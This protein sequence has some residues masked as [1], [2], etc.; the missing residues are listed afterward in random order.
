M[1]CGLGGTGQ[2]ISQQ[3]TGW[4]WWWWTPKPL[5]MSSACRGFDP[6][7]GVQV[8]HA[9]EAVE[10]IHRPPKL[11]RLGVEGADDGDERGKESEGV[12]RHPK[13]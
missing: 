11:G 7:A 4:E 12:G 8:M 2:T 9:H 3:R 5:C 1:T 13:A 6:R 10:I